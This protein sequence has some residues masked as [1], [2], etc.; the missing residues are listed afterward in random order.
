MAATA[1]P[2]SKWA[3]RWACS[4]PR[5]V[6][7]GRSMWPWRRPRTFQVDS[8]W[9]T[10]HSRRGPRWATVPDATGSNKVTFPL[11]PR[12]LGLA[13][14]VPEE[15]PQYQLSFALIGNA[16]FAVMPWRGLLNNGRVMSGGCAPGPSI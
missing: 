15:I 16:K 8:P 14:R 1:F 6:N 13:P 4:V 10:S 12:K 2:A 9:R 5:T 3:Q 11:W 7:T